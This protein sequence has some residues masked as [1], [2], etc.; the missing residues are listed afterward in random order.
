MHPIGFSYSCYT[1]NLCFVSVAIQSHLFDFS[2][3]DNI[4]DSECLVGFIEVAGSKFYR[5]LCPNDRR[6]AWFNLFQDLSRGSSPW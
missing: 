6:V 2:G 4:A 1:S 3:F 5:D